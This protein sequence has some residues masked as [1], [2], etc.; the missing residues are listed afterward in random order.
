LVT[1]SAV[2]ESVVPF[3]VSAPLAREGIVA[4]WMP[5]TVIARDPAEFVTSPVCAGSA[6]AGRVAVKATVPAVSYKSPVV[7]AVVIDVPNADPVEVTM[8]APG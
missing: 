8:P 6:A 4:P 5:P 3:D 1:W 2:H 7:A